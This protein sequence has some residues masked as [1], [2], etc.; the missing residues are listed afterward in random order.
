MLLFAIF[1]GTFLHWKVTIQ[2]LAKKIRLEN[3]ILVP[4]EAKINIPKKNQHSS[5]LYKDIGLN[6]TEANTSPTDSYTETLMENACLAAHSVSDA[7]KGTEPRHK[8]SLGA[9][10]HSLR[11]HHSR[12]GILQ[13]TVAV[14]GFLNTLGRR[15]KI[16]WRI[17]SQKLQYNEMELPKCPWYPTVSTNEQRH[18]DFAEGKTIPEA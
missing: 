1:I 8:G 11:S 10:G 5:T 12:M 6:F 4:F 14:P 17:F 15:N 18:K 3:Y 2:L 7:I 13:R 9:P 16:K